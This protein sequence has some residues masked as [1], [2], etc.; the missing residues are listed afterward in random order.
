MSKAKKRD[1]IHICQ[2]IFVRKQQYK[3]HSLVFDSLKTKIDFYEK[4]H[5]LPKGSYLLIK[6]IHQPANCLCEY[7]S[8]SSKA[9][10]FEHYLDSRCPEDYISFEGSTEFHQWIEYKNVQVSKSFEKKCIEKHNT[11][12]KINFHK[13]K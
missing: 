2:G 9:Q 1:W 7:F 11:F 8:A 13:I 3:T 6:G 5:Q 4:S 10:A 12:L